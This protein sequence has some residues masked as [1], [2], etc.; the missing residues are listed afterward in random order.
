MGSKCHAKVATHPS[1]KIKNTMYLEYLIAIIAI[2]SKYYLHGLCN[3]NYIDRLK[4][5]NIESLELRRIRSDMC[6]MYKLYHGL[7]KF[8]YLSLLRFLLIFSIL[9]KGNCFKLKKTHALLI[10]RLN[11]FVIRCA[12]N[13]NLLNDNVVCSHS[14]NLLKKRLPSFYKFIVRGHALNVY[15]DCMFLAY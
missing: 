2:Y 4:I 11:H 5:C 15:K 1:H 14:F 10:I 13:W 12:N 3:L 7:V 6:F 9:Y 8:I